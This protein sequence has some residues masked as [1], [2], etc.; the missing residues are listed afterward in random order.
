[1]ITTFLA[2]LKTGAAYVPIDPGEPPRRRSAIIDDARPRVAVADAKGRL[3]LASSG[4][5]LIAPVPVDGAAGTGNAEPAG[6]DM[7]YMMYTSGSTGVPKGVMVPHRGIVNLVTDTNYVELAPGD[8]VLQF[9]PS[10]FDVSTFEI[11]G[12]L[13]NGARLEMAPRG[14]LGAREV[15]AVVRD[16]GITVMWLTA[17]LFHRQ[18]DFDPLSLRGPRTVLAGG[19][20]LSVPHVEAL[21]AAL[22]DLE[23]VNGYGPT[24]ATTFAVCHRIGTD[25][26]LES[27]VPIGRPV[28]HVSI[29]IRDEAGTPVTD[30]TAGELWIGGVGVALGYWRRP[31]LTA[32]R[33]V[34]DRAG[35]LWYRTGDLARLRPD[36]LVDFLGRMDGQFKIR[37]H[38]VEAGEVET[39]LAGQGTIRQA[40]V[41]I[42]TNHLGDA[43][44]VAW[45]VADDARIERR[46]IRSYLRERLPDYM[47][48][49]VFV[50][51]AE[52][53]VTA[54]GKID[55]TALPDP[56]WTRKELYV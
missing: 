4:L 8:R 14:Q 45:V 7:A 31:E 27:R 53:P 16:R 9:A 11:W 28:Q 50:P 29:G 10:A 21:R 36:G 42:R 34:T 56:E 40:A 2:V 30:G 41:A 47:V 52:L 35:S 12:A 38:R 55:R 15:A 48:P 32:E 26:P 20:V 3:D 51:V 44:L 22:P 43:Q 19:D 49:A 37:G 39:T 6:D 23:I 17:A 1:M 25:E 46:A 18:I 24:E 33:F 54:N 13:L 5:R